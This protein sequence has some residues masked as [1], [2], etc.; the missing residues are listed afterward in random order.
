MKLAFRGFVLLSLQN[1]IFE[2][3]YF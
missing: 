1:S 3:S 2:G